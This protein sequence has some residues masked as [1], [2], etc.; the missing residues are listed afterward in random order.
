MFTFNLDLN[1]SKEFVIEN[2]PLVLY[3]ERG[4]KEF[5]V[6]YEGRWNLKGMKEF[7]K[8]FKVIVD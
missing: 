3:F 2:S 7:V 1:D 5:P 8:G 4:N 6:N